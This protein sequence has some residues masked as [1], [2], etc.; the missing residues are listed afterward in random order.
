M[1]VS[2]SVYVRVCTVVHAPDWAVTSNLS[3]DTQACIPISPLLA[4]THTSHYISLRL[5][6]CHTY[7]VTLVM[8]GLTY[9]LH[10]PSVAQWQ[11]TDRLLA[12]CPGGGYCSSQEQGGVPC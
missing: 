1:S 4:H 12:R 5:F 3:V 7:I 9:T 8:F 11:H 10:T 2:V 6:C